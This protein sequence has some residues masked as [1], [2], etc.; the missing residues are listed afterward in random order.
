LENSW[1]RHAKNHAALRDGWEAMGLSFIVDKA[2]R[3][4]QLNALV[5]PEGVEEAAVR[6]T[7]LERYDLEIGAGLGALA[8]NIWRVGLMGQSSST[9]HVTLFLAAMEDVLAEQGAK[10]TIG[11]ALPAARAVL[12]G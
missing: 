6:K 3:L 7:L 9:Q 4:P 10:I 12:A 5:I 11:A 1:A 2:C 8:G